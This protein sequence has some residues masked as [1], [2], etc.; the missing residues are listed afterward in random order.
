[1]NAVELGTYQQIKESLIPYVGSGSTNHLIASSSS[2]ILSACMS[3]PMDVIKTRMMN[4]AGKTQM[5]RGIVDAYYK[6]V[7][8]ESVSSL[9]S[10]FIP[11]CTRKV[12][13]CITF[14]TVYEYLL[15]LKI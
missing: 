11:I 13:W 10:G 2:G 12:I 1:M 6:I 3:T 14:F 15:T 4:Q 5:Y 7:T 8:N 9:Y